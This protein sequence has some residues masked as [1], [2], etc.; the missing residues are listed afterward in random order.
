MSEDNLLPQARETERALLSSLMIEPELVYQ[1]MT[2]VTPE[3]FFMVSHRWIYQA[4]VEIAHHNLS[5]DAITVTEQL[6]K[7]GRLNNLVA[8]GDELAAQF[9]VS[10]LLTTEAYY[11]NWQRY[12]SDIKEASKR[13]KLIDAARMIANA[14]FDEAMPID[15]AVH[16]AEY[17]VLNL[18]QDNRTDRLYMPHEYTDDFVEWLDGDEAVGLSTGFPDLD[19]C[20]GG[21]EGG[22]VYCFGGAEKMG[23]SSMLMSISRNVALQPQRPVVLRFSLEMD[24]RLMMRRDV[25]AI[26][27]VS[28]QKLKR[29]DLNDAEQ[30]AAYH[31]VAVVRDTNLIYECTA[32]ITPSAMKAKCNRVA[33]QYGKIDLICI[34]Y[35]QIMGSDERTANENEKHLRVSNEIVKLARE[36]DAP[37]IIGAQVLSKNIDHRTDKRPVL[38]DVRGS[39]A[40]QSDCYFLAFLYRDHYYNPDLSTPYE[41]E[42]I[43][44]AHRDGAAPIIPLNFDAEC[45]TFRSASRIEL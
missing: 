26:S 8:E 3:D 12:V 17:A 25:S 7:T 22:N 23:K 16:T 27:G 1:V 28:V 44:R 29:R 41:A 40:L 15:E 43:V 5:I 6:R 38:S 32:G 35:F 11:N 37:V 4:I 34:D 31:A 30:Q 13:R 20:I 39:S 21:L 19:R 24:K 14:A 45:T 36:F 33:M 10:D 9:F 18:G 2:Q 42:L